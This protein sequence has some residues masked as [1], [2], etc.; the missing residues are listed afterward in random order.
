MKKS[1]LIFAS[2][3]FS[4]GFAGDDWDQCEK[5]TYSDTLVR[6]S[7]DANVYYLTVTINNTNWVEE[8]P[9]DN[10]G[11]GFCHYGTMETAGDIDFMG[12]DQCVN[13]IPA[14]GSKTLE[15]TIAVNDASIDTILIKILLKNTIDDNL[16]CEETFWYYL[17]TLSIGEIDL[18][19]VPFTETYYDLLGRLITAPK[20][21]KIYVVKKVYENGYES[22]KKVYYAEI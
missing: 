13:P 19:A 2:L 6:D 7:L 4:L 5:A 8:F 21:N 17:P 18:T 16:Y 14:L 15:Y 9:N 10:S 11:L 1:L 12:N 3:I 20:A 22:V